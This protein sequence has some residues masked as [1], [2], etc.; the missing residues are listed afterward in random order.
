VD[1]KD[2]TVLGFALDFKET[3]SVWTEA[4]CLDKESNYLCKSLVCCALTAALEYEMVFVDKLSRE[5]N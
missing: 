1:R 4:N 5:E 3:M 2:C